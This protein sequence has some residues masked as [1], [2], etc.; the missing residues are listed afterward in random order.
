MNYFFF[1]KYLDII[2]KADFGTAKHRLFLNFHKLEKAKSKRTSAALLEEICQHLTKQNIHLCFDP[3]I[4]L[5]KIYPE[6][7]LPII[8]ESTYAHLLTASLILLEKC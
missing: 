8:H 6:D 1:Q 2:H 5:L 7:A 4:I 3:A